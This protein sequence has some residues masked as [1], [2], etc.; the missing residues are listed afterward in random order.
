MTA[1]RVEGLFDLDGD[2]LE[3]SSFEDE[4]LAGDL[5]KDLEA[6]LRQALRR[7]RTAPTGTIQGKTL[8]QLKSLGYLD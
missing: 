8:E 7:K 1:A 6:I 2:P 4:R 3:M 5:R